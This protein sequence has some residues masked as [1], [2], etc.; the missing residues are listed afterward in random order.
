MTSCKYELFDPLP[1]CHA[2]VYYALCT[3]ATQSQPPLPTCMI[4]FIDVPK[5]LYCIFLL[6]SYEPMNKVTINYNTR[7]GPIQEIIN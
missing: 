1:I 4:S 6:S 3:F 2:P 7:K 5:V